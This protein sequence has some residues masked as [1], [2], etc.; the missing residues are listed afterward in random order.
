MFI[1]KQF[2]LEMASKI[3][4]SLYEFMVFSIMDIIA[5]HHELDA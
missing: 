2:D 4:T 5:E 3:R 1:F